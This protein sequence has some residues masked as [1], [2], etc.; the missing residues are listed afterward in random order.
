M[1]IDRSRGQ[2]LF[3]V[4]LIFVAVIVE[5]LLTC[6][7]VAW[8]VDCRACRFCRGKR[9][10]KEDLDAR[11]KDHIAAGESARQIA[12]L[13][14]GDSILRS[15]IESWANHHPEAVWPDVRLLKYRGSK[16]PH[17][18]L[19]SAFAACCLVNG[20]CIGTDKLGHL[21]QTGWEY[22]AISVIDGK[23][24]AL[25]R[26]YGEWLE[27]KEPRESYAEDESYFQ[28]QFAGR[29]VGYGGYGR[30][31]SGVISNADL[32][33]NSAGLQMYKDISAGR[34]VSI[35]NYVSKMLC[36]EVNPNDYTA[37]MKEIVSRNERANLDLLQLTNSLSI[38]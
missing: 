30:I 15:P 29:S 33:A 8:E 21:F 13:E 35:A 5:P 25:A 14:G 3:G 37:D 22:Y 19:F 36:E 23:G 1:Q 24:D 11:I 2:S 31:V 18:A 28:K 6:T 16:L 26:R 34:F 9:D 4:C 38:K 32:A 7:T 17:T 10:I 12:A 27:G 20:V